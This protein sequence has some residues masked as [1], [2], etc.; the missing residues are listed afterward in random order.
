MSRVF[1]QPYIFT[2]RAVVIR[3]IFQVCQ[4]KKRNLYVRIVG[5]GIVTLQQKQMLPSADP[6]GRQERLPGPNFFLLIV[7]QFWGAICQI[8]LTFVVD[9]PSSRKSWIHHWLPCIFGKYCDLIDC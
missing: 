3:G 6:R 7:M 8:R 4:W 1:V 2:K 9:V 5:Y